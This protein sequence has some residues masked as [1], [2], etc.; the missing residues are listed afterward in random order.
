M[1]PVYLDVCLDISPFTSLTNH[2]LD[3]VQA[4][5][6]HEE[7]WLLTPWTNQSFSGEKTESTDNHLDAFDDYLE[8]QQINGADTNV[9]Q[10]ITIFGYSLFGKAKKWF[11]QGR[12]GRPHAT[13][14]DWNGLKEQF[15][16]QFN[17][18]GNT[19]EE[20]MA[21]WRNINWDG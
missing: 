1:L 15:K 14:A 12:D 10:I 17:P 8:I 2:S 9:A 4:S 13:V 21:S 11:N 5:K 3:K 16:Q 6:V 19:R 20:Q 7:W 18:V